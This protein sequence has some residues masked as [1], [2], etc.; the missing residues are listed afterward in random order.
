MACKAGLQQREN[1]KCIYFFLQGKFNGEKNQ[2][3]KY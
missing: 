3:K 1:I 2:K